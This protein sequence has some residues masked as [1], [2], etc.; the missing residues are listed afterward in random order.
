MHSHLCYSL[1]RRVDRM[2]QSVGTVVSKIDAVIVK[3]DAVEQAKAKR[4]ETAV[5]V[6]NSLNEVK[7]N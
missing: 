6:L 2:E 5:K 4:H 7:A 3:L 1:V